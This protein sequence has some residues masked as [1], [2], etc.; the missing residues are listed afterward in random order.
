MPKTRPGQ[1]LVV[2]RKGRLVNLGEAASRVLPPGSTWV[3]VPGTQLEAGFEMTQE[4]KD[5]IPLRFKGSVIHRILRPE[6]TAALF[7]FDTGGTESIAASI[8]QC[9]LAELRDAVSRLSMNECIEGRKTTLTEAVRKALEALVAGGGG[10]GWGVAIEVVQVA[11]VFIVD[12]GLRS[13]L[14]AGTRNEILARSQLAQLGAEEEVKLAQIASARRV[15]DEALATER[16]RAALEAEKLALAAGLERRKALEGIET[17]RTRAAVERE[18]LALTTAAEAEALEAEAPVRRRRNELRMEALRGELALLELEGAR[19]GLEVSRD[20][21][22][23]RAEQELALEIL[24]V[25]QRP[26][27]AEA[28][29][30]VLNGAKLSVYGEGERLLGS[31]EPLLGMLATALGKDEEAKA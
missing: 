3:K 25:E 5:G 10:E 21:A 7:D 1:F 18:R 29:A 27:I 16:Q 26:L 20:F 31:L 17:E 8:R 22:A 2:A 23:K 13:Q 4:T 12:A 6:L 24:P 11:Q 30:K 14:E 19:A 28:A 9:C 15:Q